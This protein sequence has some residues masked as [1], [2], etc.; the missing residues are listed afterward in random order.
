[1]KLEESKEREHGGT[2][3]FNYR[4]TDKAQSEVC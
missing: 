4:N 3:K 2:E 1:M